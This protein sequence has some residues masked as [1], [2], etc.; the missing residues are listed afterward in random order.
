MLKLPG[1]GRYAYSPSSNG[2][3]MSGRGA[4]AWRSTWRSISSIS[5]SAPGWAMDPCTIAAAAPDAR[6]FAWRDYG[7]RVGKW[8][9]FELLDQ[10]KFARDDPA[11]QQR[12]LLLPGYR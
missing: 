1:H 7:N 8:R 3:A 4:S 9:M 6:A 2:R 5:P 10:L 11:Q 12:L